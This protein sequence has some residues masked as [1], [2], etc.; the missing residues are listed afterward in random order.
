VEARTPCPHLPNLNVT[1]D[2]EH[3]RQCGRNRGADFY[4][5]CLEY[6]QYLWI[7]DTPARSLLAI[8]R[9]LFADINGDEDQLAQWP[10]PYAG[11]AWILQHAPDQAFIGNP[12][13]HFQHLADRIRDPRRPVKSWRAWACWHIVRKCQPE[14]EGD[15][16]HDVE[17]PSEGSVADALSRHGI[18]GETDLWMSVLAAV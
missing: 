1:L 15:P 12:R 14:L 2:Y 4:L 11:V 3:L 5:R 10:L 18:P 17:P 13:I 16:R 6:A 8:D 9:A 7:N